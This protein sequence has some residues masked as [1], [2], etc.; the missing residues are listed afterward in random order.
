MLIVKRHAMQT[1][2][3]TEIQMYTRYNILQ[4][5]FIN[6]SRVHLFPL[7]CCCCLQ[8]LFACIQY[9]CKM[10]MYVRMPRQESSYINLK[11]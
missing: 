11:R 2:I 7:P 4:C 8:L 9:T 3:H 6:T 10:C 1:K 5:I